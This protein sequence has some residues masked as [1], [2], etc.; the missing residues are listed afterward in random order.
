VHPNDFQKEKKPLFLS[1]LLT[2]M[3]K[4]AKTTAVALMACFLVGYI[5]ASAGRGTDLESPYLKENIIAPLPDTLPPLE[6]RMGD[7]MTSPQ[8]N[9]F[10]LQ[11]PS[12]IQ[13]S[14]EYDPGSGNYIINEK[15][16]EDYFRAPTYMTY[17]EYLKWSEEK[18]R[19]AYFR[20]LADEAGGAKR[21]SN[22][23][24]PIEKIVLER[25]LKPGSSF[26]KYKQSLKDLLNKGPFG[27]GGI[28]IEPKGNI[29]LTFGYDR[30]FLENPTLP[31]RQ[32][33]SGGFDFDMNIQM[34]VT[35][36]IGDKLQLGTNYNT[37]ATFDFDNQMRLAHE[38]T[39]DEIIQKI[40]A[41]NI[42]LPLRSSLIQGSQSLFGLKTE[43]KFGKLYLT[44]VLS[45]Q[46]SRRNN[47]QV[48]GGSTVQ[49]FD[50][51][52]DRY[53]QDRH[54]FLTHY[55][56]DNFEYALDKLPQIRSLFKVTR[57]EVWVTNTRNQT[58]NVRE[59][60]ALTDLGE[61]NATDMTNPN[62][63]IQPPT[64]PV[65]RDIN[66]N[67]L[68]SNEANPLYRLVTSNSQTRNI[69]NVITQLQSSYGLR[70]TRDFEKVRGRLLSPNEF[71]MHPDLGFISMNTVLNPSDVV[72]VA[73]EYTYNGKP[74]KIGEFSRDLGATPDSTGVLF[75]KMLK[76]TTLQVGI[77]LWDLMMKNVYSLGAFQVEQKDFKLDV[78]YD[79][80]GG[81]EKRFLPE[82]NL[83]GVPLIQ[84]LNMDNLNTQSDPQPDGVFDF[85]PGLTILPQSG[86]IIFPVLEPF[87]T[88]LGKQIDD[89]LLRDKYVYQQLYDSTLVRA[90]EYSE[91]NRFRIKGSYRSSRSS[92]ISLGAINVPRGSVTVTAG[93][94]QLQEG[95]DYEIDYNIGQIR[96]LNEAY[97]SSGTPINV[98]YED[99]ALFGFQQ[100]T[101]IGMRADY[102][103][104]K[105][106]N[107]GATW[108]RLSERPYTQKVNIGDDPIRNNIY[109][110]DINLHKD[111]PWLTRFLDRLPLLQTKEASSFSFQA[112]VAYLDPG[113]PK[114]I[115]Q[116]EE[117][118]VVLL[119][120]FEGS[121]TTYDLRIPAT[122]WVLASTPQNGLPL[123]K[124][125]SLVNDLA[126]GANRA[127]LTWYQIDQTGVRGRGNNIITPDQNDNYNR[128][129]TLKEVFKNVNLDPTQPNIVR[130]FDLTYYPKERGPYNFDVPGGI[131]GYTDGVDTDGNLNSPEKR[132]GGIMRG[133][134]NT[135]FE[136]ANF[137]YIDMWVM[138]PFLKNKDGVE[139]NLS[140]GY[141]NINLGNV[142]EDILR[143]SR[144]F[145][146]NSLPTADQQTR[147]DT[148]SWAR[149][150]RTPPV[151]NA[152]DNNTDSRAN[153][154]LGLDGLDDVGERVVFDNYLQTI[155]ASNLPNGIKQN[156]QNDPSAD[157]FVHYNNLDS[158]GETNDFR[159]R[160]KDFNG[161][162]G[163]SKSAFNSD[164][165]ESSTNTPDAEDI[166]RDN[167]LNEAESYYLYR[168]PIR[169]DASDGIEVDGRFV[170][171]EVIG[172]KGAKFYHVRVPLNQYTRK[173]GGIQDFR[174]IRFMRTYLTEFNDTTTLRF[175]RFEL[176]RNQW[177]K[178]TRS[179]GENCDFVTE[180]EVGDVNVEENGS[181][182]P[183]N[184]V[185]PP[186][187]RQEEL[188]GQTFAN[189]NA[190]QN[191]R[192]M[193]MRLCNLCD[194]GSRG[195][196]KILN[197]DMRLYD[198]LRM[199]VHAESED[200]LP[201]DGVSL[202]MRI[203]SDFEN[204]Y[205]EYEIPLTL[206]DPNQMPTKDEAYR[207]VVW[208]EANNFN[209]PLDLL[210]TV[211][212]ARNNSGAPV[213]DFYQIDVDGSTQGAK[214]GIVGNPNLGNVKGI[215]IGVRNNEDDRRP[216]CLDVWLNELRLVGLNERGGLAGLARMDLKLAD[217]GNI[218]LAGNYTGVG[219][220]ALDQRLQQRQREEV[221]QMDASTQLEL[222]K[223]LP[224]KTG[225]KIPFY[226][227]YSNTTK[228]PEYDPYDY[229]LTVK[230]KLRS[231]N[232][233]TV[234]DS[235]REQVQEVTE[236]RN[237]AFTNVRKERT[238]PEQKPMPWNIENFSFDYAYSKTENRTP[239]ISSNS[240]NV[241]RGG[242][243]Y[244][245][246]TKGF[247]V[248]PFK[249]L[250]K[251]DKY[252]KFLTEFNLNLLPNSFTFNTEMDKQQQV[253]VYR[254]SD[255]NNNT[256]FN[257]RF[258]WDR[259]YGLQ[260]DFTKALRFRF[261]AVNS[262]S[263]DEIN[264]RT[265]LD[266]FGNTMQELGVASRKEYVWDNIKQFGRNK[267][268]QQNIDLSYDV[269]LKNFFFLDW[270]TARAAYRANYSWTAASTEEF[271]IN[272]G[273]IIQNTQNRSIN[274]DIDFEKL[275]NKWDY[276]KKI[277]SPKPKTKPKAPKDKKTA[278][279]DKDKPAD[280][281][282]KDK[283]KKKDRVP[284]IAER[285]LIR[286]LMALRKG[287]ITYSEDFGSVLP[288]FGQTSKHFGLSSDWS[289][290]GWDFVTGLRQANE[291]WLLNK[292]AANGWMSDSTYLVN[293]E[294]QTV[295]KKD[296]DLKAT[297]EPF[298]EFNID[299]EMNQKRTKNTL[300][301]F[302]EESPNT[303]AFSYL[304]PR[305]IGSY[306][307]SF[308]P[309]RTFFEKD[310]DA[311]YARFENNR[312]A[313]SQRLGSL[314]N[315]TAPHAQHPEYI[316]GFGPY[317]QDVLIPAF[318][319][320]YAGIDPQKTRLQV[321]DY[322]PLPNWR[323]NYSGL[324]K[325]DAFK[326][327]FSRF[328]L[329]HGYKSALT[330]N[331]YT[332]DLD[333]DRE[334]P[335][336]IS[337]YNRLTSDYFTRLEIPAVVI[338]EQFTPLLG[339]DMSFKNGMTARLDWKKSRNLA[340][341][342][343]DNQ[344]IENNTKE[345]AFGFNYVMKDVYI[346]F[347]DVGRKQREAAEKRKKKKG[348]DKEDDN[349]GPIT[350]NFGQGNKKVSKDITFGFDVSVRD[351]KTINRQLDRNE[352]VPTRGSKTIRV[353]PTINYIM[354]QNMTLRLFFD[355]NRTIPVVSSSFPQTRTAGG[356]VVSFSLN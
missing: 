148:T 225:V 345:I 185:L 129:I 113:H 68:P 66:G 339:V 253:T 165:S 94:V 171:E 140:D 272:L 89:P 236:I 247:F 99:N 347:L 354:N 186:G 316:E 138:S 126:Y 35:G 337:N 55:N 160:Y 228:N 322:F 70:L 105:D 136:Q 84:A 173:V 29:D 43:L 221:I 276:L 223:L 218:S 259:E 65:N 216:V 60:V 333:Y 96:I 130:T 279:G 238:N 135:D 120:D 101:M 16:G 281:K 285:I 282:D 300:A 163:N 131:A 249:K 159:N 348:D 192:S 74:Y 332:T 114:V 193:S 184:Y 118:G 204:N 77:P 341:G 251:K 342:L 273:N 264:Q 254:F 271:A 38:G 191:E 132:W 292:V 330:V 283:D 194:G 318:I 93:G 252:L 244:G 4:I 137:E 346:K 168:I 263:V 274:G 199:F 162:Q 169:K 301:F 22:V 149:I 59:I 229:D 57:L 289:S 108:M 233:Q 115:N 219:Y 248:Y 277:N 121:S 62:P 150:S 123:F 103:L 212:K 234:K 196:F 241:H 54:F 174:S 107:I 308:M 11:D 290:P 1:S 329:T 242:L 20:Q 298:K 147:T 73:V 9:P 42:S 64:A 297:L 243:N 311:V 67:G 14:V 48:Q 79:D 296:L 189:S 278:D 353:S 350:I 92:T 207:K 158:Y 170:L 142:S 328:S 195:I 40:E 230:E 7:F 143:D 180:F 116:N 334:D 206:S 19:Q 288:G 125:A 202:Y 13:Q 17:E 83:R 167:T 44:N 181:R 109:G 312:P 217:F 31:R 261:N 265:G 205:Y 188:V 340:L 280:A 224:E 344:L 291:D 52:A 309:L 78:Y 172:D 88:S 139:S 237:F 46:K 32:Q 214:V 287:R 257:N 104:S 275:Y 45:Q 51:T 284:S 12:G 335:F 90:Q 82:T 240:L 25:E 320:A 2:D 106:V 183:F 166:N 154:D 178:Y 164:V 34:N 232:S 255:P 343:L 211:K 313:I 315:L 208:P 111:A 58:E 145:F 28:V 215:L 102:K 270:M 56:R 153:Q 294:V 100:K 250:I 190:L 133:L 356:L 76:S 352:K 61:P 231:A 119:D 336:S 299:V 3:N 176:V 146:E 304:T 81:G 97:I 197:Y 266:P 177:R 203:G 91:L 246:T 27:D 325:L 53:D 23:K 151:T 30:S 200:P 157:D 24:D 71:T 144:Q 6:E 317:H 8:N 326:N 327:V 10:D 122:A 260:W 306:T 351:D 39:E 49:Y 302:K 269:P 36:K 134:Q 37:Q 187:V 310:L 201:P 314:N 209:F 267:A 15:I 18:Q 179:L 69:D 72:G 305:E 227:S 268:Y 323:L 112:E 319:S 127:K 293:Q 213:S 256:W 235:I 110:F 47:L 338:S 128:Q 286:P 80:P 303:S 95:I 239:L 5:F 141:L 41:G 152:F 124:E 182:L 87:G 226:A 85:V 321:F 295:Y 355:Y 198:N 245:Y 155:A 50:V 75:V 220:G 258:V 86:K 98:S 222:G 63:A 331:N 26:D 210:T 307:I 175:V 156:I 33:R 117:S 324:S 262:A 21:V 161:V 349:K